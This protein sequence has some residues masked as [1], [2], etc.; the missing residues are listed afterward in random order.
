M[1]CKL[2]LPPLIH[3]HQEQITLKNTT[4]ILCVILPTC[5]PYSEESVG[6]PRTRVR[7]CELGTEPE[8]PARTA[9]LAHMLSLIIFQQIYLGE[10]HLKIFIISAQRN[11][12]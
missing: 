10:I 8:S 9:R 2:S 6:S 11:Q 12:R 4:I 7:S 1:Q 5:V 3:H